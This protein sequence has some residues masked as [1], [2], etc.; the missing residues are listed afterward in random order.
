VYGTVPDDDHL[1]I[2][3]VGTVQNKGIEFSLNWKDKINDKW[4][5][6][7]GGNVTFNKNRIVALNGG[8][9]IQ[10]GGIGASQGFVT[11]TDNGQP[12]G[13]FH[14]LQVIGV[15]NSDADA[16]N[17]KDANGITIQPTAH[18]GDFKYLDANGDGKIDD[19]DR[20]FAGSY[21]PVAY[22]GGNVSFSY[23]TEK[24]GVW[25]FSLSIYGNA[26][27]KVY[28]GKKAVRISGTDNVERDLVYNRWTHANNTQAQPGANV[29]NLPGSTYFVESGS[30]IR[31]NNLT[32]G[33][34][35]PTP[36]LK[37]RV[38]ATSQ[39]LFTLK[40]YSGFTAELPG[41]PLDSG[42]ELSSYPTTRTV[43]LGV[44]VTF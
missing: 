31:I 27:N 21:Q 25:D 11:M 19:S 13:S 3:N 24:K 4:S 38:Y 41:G 44:N 16:T 28:N 30:F 17:Y 32:V 6:T 9:A 2:R 15:F 40:K 10:R 26:G 7:V 37:L 43:S 14:V 8:Q 29:G 39:N 12:V 42:I 35:F 18:A 20:V 22:Y 33:Y 34:T 1:I 23:T 36:N 5:Y